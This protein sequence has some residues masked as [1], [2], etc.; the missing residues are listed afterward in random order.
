ME[1]WSLFNEDYSVEVSSKGRVRN[2]KTKRILKLYNDTNGYQCVRVYRYSDKK[3]I[4]LKV[5]ILVAMAFLKKPKEG[6]VIDHID[7]N[8]GNNKLDNLRWVTVSQNNAYSKKKHCTPVIVC[9]EGLS[10]FLQ[11]FDTLTEATK[12]V[13]RSFRNAITPMTT[14]DG[15]WAC[16]TY[17]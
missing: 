17:E 16:K 3:G 9:A 12:Y 4:T 10:E 7:G 5:H 14:K 11:E 2:R 8:R 1:K 13:N 6:Y 15:V